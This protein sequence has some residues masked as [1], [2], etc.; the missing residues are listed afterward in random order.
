M[1]KVYQEIE[2]I[3]TTGIAEEYLGEDVKLVEH[4]LQCGDLAREAGA[5]D[6]LVVASLLTTSAI[7]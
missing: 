2:K 4:M 1:S 5:P 3:F 6:Y 7:S